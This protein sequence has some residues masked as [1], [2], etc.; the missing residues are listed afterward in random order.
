MYIVKK[1]TLDG[2]SSVQETFHKYPTREEL[3][4]IVYQYFGD[5]KSQE[6]SEELFNSQYASINDSRCTEFEIEKI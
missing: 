4:S 6:A 3:Y 5:E 1:T 2:Y